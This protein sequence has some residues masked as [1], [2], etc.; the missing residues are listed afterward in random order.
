VGLG[1]QW[2]GASACGRWAELGPGRA[3]GRERGG[4]GTWAGIGPTGG[5]RGIP[6]S[7]S[8]SKSISL[9]PSLFPLNK[10]LFRFL[11]CPN[12]LCEVLLTIMV[13][14]YD[15]FNAS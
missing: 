7:F 12:I 9:S 11:W 6:F 13:Y 5:E 8:I 4:G 10:Y 14:A 15:E 3:R 1:W 2:R